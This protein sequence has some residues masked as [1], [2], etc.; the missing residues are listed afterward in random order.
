MEF[1]RASGVL[2]HPTSFPGPHGIGDLGE[3][4]FRFVDWLVRAGQRLWQVLP[5]C[6]T[7]HGNSPYAAPSAFAGNPLL[8]SLSWLAGDGL[9]DSSEIVTE[10]DA[11]SQEVDVAR[12]IAFKSPLLRR[13]FERFSETGAGNQRTEFEIF[14][15]DEAGWLDDYALFMAVKD[16]HQGAPWIEW[17][18]AIALRQ[19][20]SI[21]LWTQRLKDDIRYHQFIQFQFR[22]QWTELRRYANDRDVRVIGDLPIFVAHDSADVWS[23]RH[24]FRLDDNGQP[25]VVAGVP[26]DAFTDA[27]Q[28]WGN[29]L[30]AWDRM[31]N[32]GFAWWIHRVRTT[33]SLVD[34][35]R[36]DHF[37]AFAAAWVVPR[38]APTAASGRW[39]RGPGASI[40]TALR[41]ALGD[42]PFIVEDL[43]LITD[44]VVALREELLLPGMK[45]LQFAFD[46]GPAN[47][48]LPHNYHP[49]CV[50]YTATHDNQTTIGWMQSRP[51]W[52]R[53]AIQRYLGRDGS[54]ISWDLIRLALGSV[55][56]I[57]VVPLQDVMRLGDE[58][59]MNTPGRATGN[60]GW[61]YSSQQLADDL[62]EGL[63]DLTSTYG[64]RATSGQPSGFNPY[65]Y[66]APATAHPLH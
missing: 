45:V 18:R 14:C 9:L 48:Y 21:G 17:P 30:F 3:S 36:I 22:R 19:P 57:A 4:A 47:A 2:V 34:F 41:N 52:E 7:G 32:D 16:E 8:I 51:D 55:A 13:A 46:S 61:R 58:A 44:D 39:E 60:W 27:G 12:V 59:R 10:G 42:L 31:A 33:L 6:P 64:R 54:D 50:V 24:L 15:R 23:N 11:A 66:T 25:T 37:R 28:R 1:P 38:E 53:R 63:A 43:G 29:P 35:L 5:L 56:N 20:G 62:A 65:D 40:F 26:P 49:D